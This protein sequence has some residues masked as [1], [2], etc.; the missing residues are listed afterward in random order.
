MIDMRQITK[1]YRSRAVVT[2]ALDTVDLRVAEG[3][4]VA[5][6]GPSGCG[7]STLLNIAGLLDMP[8]G[9][10][11]AFMGERV[12]RA[13]EARRA[14]IRKARI[15]F[16]FQNFNLIEDLT[17]RENVD[18]ALV[19]HG[20]APSRRRARV[21]AVLEDLGI[22]HRADSRPQSLSGGQQQRVAIARALVT[23]PRLLLADEPTG[24]LDSQTGEDVM[25]I[26]RRVNDQGTTIVMVTHSPAHAHY[27]QRTVN[28][29]DGRIV[30][31]NVRGRA[32][33]LS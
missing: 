28:L 17:V 26:L 33:D 16:I 30:A 6:M 31:E 10:T 2:H 19:Y 24:N 21:D 25:G 15:G 29:L 32:P 5:I 11:Y 20:L 3:D 13:G 23:R 7:K 1:S 12:E 9:G 27:A 22:S 14:Q 18:L 8:D 4:F